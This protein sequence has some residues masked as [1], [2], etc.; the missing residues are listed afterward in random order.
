MLDWD[1]EIGAIEAAVRSFPD[2]SVNEIESGVGT[3]WGVLVSTIISLRTKDAVTLV[4]SRNLLSAAADP[5][6]LLSMGEEKVA[7]IIYPAGFYRTKAANLI[8]IARILIDDFQGN[9]PS[10]KEALLALPGVGLKT[11]NLVLGVGFRIPA[12]CVDIH[13]HRIANR[14]GWLISD[15]PDLTEK[16][17]GEILPKKWW[18]DIN[19]ILVSFGQKICTPVSPHCSTCPVAADCPRAGVARFR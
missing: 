18:I 2:P 12:I 9:V 13:V 6:T 16:L 8:R 11:A 19:R 4:S 3:P 14:L 17:L 10:N 1:N 5:R 15:K 7:K